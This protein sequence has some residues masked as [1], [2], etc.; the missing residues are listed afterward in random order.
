MILLIVAEVMFFAALVSAYVVL[1][2]GAGPRWRPV[3]VPPFDLGL[4]ILNGAVLLA[5]GLALGIAVHAVRRD[6]PTRQK[7][8]LWLTVTL[9]AGFLLGQCAEFTRLWHV[10][11]FQGNVYGGVFY[12]ISWL[13][14]LHV[15]VGL[16]ILG[17]VIKASVA[18]RYHRY[19]CT[20]LIVGS[21]Y[22]WFVA[23]VWVFLFTII[24]LV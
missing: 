24:Y 21:L 23:L 9:G 11:P 22:W 18:G 15:V 8:F 13:H 7:A 20:G 5:S 10:V 6:D 3:D 4:P 14:G 17:F 1:R 12:T 2:M 16:V 19:R